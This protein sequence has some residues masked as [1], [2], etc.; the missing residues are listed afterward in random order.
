MNVGP[1]ELAEKLMSCGFDK[2]PFKALRMYYHSFLY[3][4]EP[5]THVVER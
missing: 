5:R 4:S 1:I 3:A 2:F